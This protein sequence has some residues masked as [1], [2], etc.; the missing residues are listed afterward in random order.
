MVFLHFVPSKNTV[1]S[2]SFR[3]AAI[4]KKILILSDPIMFDRV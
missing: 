2:P 1:S 3:T 4:I